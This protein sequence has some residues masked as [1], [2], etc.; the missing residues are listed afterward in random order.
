MP[1]PKSSMNADGFVYFAQGVLRARCI[2][3]SPRDGLIKIGWTVNPTD[4]LETLQSMS[5]VILRILATMPGSMRTEQELHQRFGVHRRHGEWFEP[6]DDLVAFIKALDPARADI[7]T[8][9]PKL[10][11][12]RQYGSM[13][14]W[15]Q[16]QMTP[17]EE[18]AQVESL[19]RAVQALK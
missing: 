2:G 10:G 9:P 1:A 3:I 7:D 18:D 19:R 16:N 12:R 8:R 5:P 11:R 17:E 15:K 13:A 6:A 14:V 4:R